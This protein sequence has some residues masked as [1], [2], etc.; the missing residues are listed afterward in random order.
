MMVIVM[1]CSHCVLFSRLMFWTEAQKIVQANL[2]G[3]QKRVFLSEITNYVSWP[4]G[5]TLD[6]PSQ[7]LYWVDAGTRTIGS[8]RTDGK[9]QKLLY[10][11]NITYPFGI[12]VFEDQVSRIIKAE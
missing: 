10:N 2:D 4:T 6:L 8:C 12:T 5:L 11:G 7:T 9:H 3:T 1:F